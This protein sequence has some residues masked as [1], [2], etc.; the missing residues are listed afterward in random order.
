MARK[1][2]RVQI[3]G[4]S[5]FSLAGI[6]DCP[7]D[8]DSFP[9]VVLSHCFTC[10]K[11]LKAIVRIS[12]GLAE[13]GIGVLRYD[14]TGLGGSQ[15]DFAQTNFTTNRAD[16]LSAIR[17]VEQELGPISA[18]IGH[19]FGGAA[20]LAIAGSEV[21]ARQPAVVTIAA[22]SDTVHLAAL[23][24]KMN[25]E[26]EKTG[27][28]RVT[29]GGLD[30]KI[31]RQ[32]LNDFRQV[33]LP[34]LIAKITSPALLFHSPM[35]ETL[36]YDHAIRIMGLIQNSSLNSAPA[37]LISLHGAD[38]LLAK[39]QADIDLVVSI[40]AAFVTRFASRI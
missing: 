40:T 20:T 34:A 25:P 3:P 27:S 11:D 31:Q 12:R 22:P 24:A 21:L 29:I 8:L 28:G 36:S 6:I 9:V 19:S 26:I 37:S 2:Y 17:F 13:F 4:G 14:M 39:H 30:W 35:D 5:G 33:D 1:S 32:M 23:L 16:L 7:D 18:L 10:N 15:G 38:H